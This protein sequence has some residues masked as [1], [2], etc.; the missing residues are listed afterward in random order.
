MKNKEISQKKIE[1]FTN[2]I[3]KNA[4]DCIDLTSDTSSIPIPIP[5]G[6]EPPVSTTKTKLREYNYC[7]TYLLI[8]YLSLIAYK[9]TLI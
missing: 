4:D 6:D 8:L 5:S 7:N 1:K 2:I 9:F 3:S